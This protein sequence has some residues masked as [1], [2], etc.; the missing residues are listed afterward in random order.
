MD[1]A[2]TKMSSKGQVVIPAQMREGLRE[3]DKLLLIRD[4]GS[5]IL[6]K[7]SQTEKNFEQDL[8]LARR[9]EAALK[10]YE[11]G[12]FKSKPAQ[13]FLQELKRW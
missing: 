10:K 2:I 4:N 13:D 7:A 3:G 5:F 1:I 11:K 8:A 9:A 12:G 6:K